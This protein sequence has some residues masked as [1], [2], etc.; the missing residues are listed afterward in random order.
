MVT[1]MPWAVPLVAS[2]A[3]TDE[4]QVRSSD[5]NNSAQWP[6]RT[7]DGAVATLVINRPPANALTPTFC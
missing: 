3:E 7:V 5:H 6:F 4:N 1:T 2:I